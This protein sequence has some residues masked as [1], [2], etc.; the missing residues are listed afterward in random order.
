MLVLAQNSERPRKAGDFFATALPSRAR[1]RFF[2]PSFPYSASGFVAAPPWN[3]S[4]SRCDIRR[5][6]CGGSAQVGFRYSLQTGY[7]GWQPPRACRRRRRGL[8]GR[9]LHTHADRSPRPTMRSRG[10]RARTTLRLPACDLPRSAHPGGAFLFALWLLGAALPSFDLSSKPIVLA[11]H[12]QQYAPV[13]RICGP[14]HL[15]QLARL[16]AAVFGVH[17]KPSV[18]PQVSQRCRWRKG[19]TASPSAYPC[20]AKSRE[21]RAASDS[22]APRSSLNRSVSSCAA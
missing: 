20:P 6:S 10:C 15:A 3:S 18:S 4:S 11:G 9:Y 5:V 8:R 19:G 16:G 7:S 13:A 2:P 1:S 14:S 12:H 21:S 22:T 17:V